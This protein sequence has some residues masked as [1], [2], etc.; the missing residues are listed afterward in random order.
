MSGSPLIFDNFPSFKTIVENVT[1]G[2][3]LAFM[4]L[5]KQWNKIAPIR[6]TD[7]SYETDMELE[8]SK[9]ASTRTETSNEDTLREM[10]EGY[11]F[12]TSLKHYETKMYIG[13]HQRRFAAKRNNFL[14][15]LSAYNV[16]SISTAQEYEG[17]NVRNNGFSS[18]YVGGDAV[19]L[20][21]ASHVWKSSTTAYDNLLASAP[22]AKGTAETA[23]IRVAQ[24]TVEHGIP[25]AAKVKDIHFGTDNYFVIPEIYA[26]RQDPETNHNAE[27]MLAKSPPNLNLNNYF[28][29]TGSYFLDTQYE[30]ANMLQAGSIE[31]SS[32]EDNTGAGYV[33]N[34]L[35][36]F[37]GAG[38]K[39]PAGTYGSD[40]GT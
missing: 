35:T 14:G 37:F 4:T 28:T 38:F 27:N 1:I 32:Y 7:L 33:V 15:Q 29:D 16:R 34:K 12:T 22:F 39:K 26:S 18:S 19:C 6:N 24:S 25:M 17:A 30:C 9:P 5:E 8:G 20:Y 11:S 31:P 2:T 3:T 13:S 40:G 21:S 23:M 10:K 36:G